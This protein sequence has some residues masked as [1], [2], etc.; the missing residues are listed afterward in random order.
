[1]GAVLKADAHCKASMTE[2]KD[3]I[4]EMF[5]LSVNEQAWVFLLDQFVEDIR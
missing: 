1:M 3:K 4:S 5:D 2:L